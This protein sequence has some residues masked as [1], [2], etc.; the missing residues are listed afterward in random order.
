MLTF[1]KARMGKC[2]PAVKPGTAMPKLGL[3]ADEAAAA[4]AYLYSIQPPTP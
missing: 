1:W 2:P 3:S 4:A